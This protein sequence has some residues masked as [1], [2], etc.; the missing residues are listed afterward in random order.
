MEVAQ[1]E[2]ASGR[3]KMV[4]LRIGSASQETMDPRDKI[5]QESIRIYALA[6]KMTKKKELEYLYHASNV[7]AKVLHSKHKSTD[8]STS[9]QH[10]SDIHHGV[11]GVTPNINLQMRPHLLSTGQT[12]IME[13]GG[14]GTPNINM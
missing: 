4:C 5:A 12:F 3:A 9:T 8:E 10:R 14:G 13:S 11:G 1:F 2:K 7:R 6:K